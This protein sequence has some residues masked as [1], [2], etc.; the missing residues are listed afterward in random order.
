MTEEPPDAE[1]SKWLDR[2]EHP[3]F[4]A[5][6]ELAGRWGVYNDYE[7]ESHLKALLEDVAPELQRAPAL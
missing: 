4:I 1:A 5:S 2:S 3:Y 6:P 7:A